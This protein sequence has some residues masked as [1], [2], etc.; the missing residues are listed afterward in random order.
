MNIHKSLKGLLLAATVAVTPIAI[1]DT[2][3]LADGT[4]VDGDISK[5][6][7]GQV[8]IAGTS[9]P[10]D[11]FDAASQGAIKSWSDSNP[12][13]VDVYTK[14]DSNPVIKSSSMPKVPDSVNSPGFKGMVSLDL[15]LD[16]KGK[17]I[18]A[19]VN[20]ST[21]PELEEVSVVAAKQWKFAPAKL[22]GKAVKAKLRVPFK[23]T[24]G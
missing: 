2:Y 18:F 10:L 16:Q 17:V 13:F 24:G 4:A 7:D 5:I 20:K 3:T 22:G 14:W 9:Y 19:K 11:G 12:H 15:V 8:S 23:F 21:H 1:A 6:V